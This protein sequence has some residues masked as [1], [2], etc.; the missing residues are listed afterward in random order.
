MEGGHQ[1]LHSND[2]TVHAIVNGELYDYQPLR[3]QL[4][5]AGCTFQTS[6]DSELIVHLYAPEDYLSFYRVPTYVST[7]IRPVVRTC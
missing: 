5:E 2:G 4:E 6:S 1:P 7:G 3:K